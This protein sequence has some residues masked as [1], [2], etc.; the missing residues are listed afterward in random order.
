[1]KKYILLDWDGNLAKTLDVWL[2]VLRTVFEK[3]GIHL[4]DEEIASSFGAFN[5]YAKAW[6]VQDVDVAAEEADALAKQKLPDVE[7]YPDALEVLAALHVSDRKLAL[8]TTSPHRNV[9]HLLEKYDITRYFD[10]II[11]GDDVQNHKP[12]PEP[13][14]KAL[15]KLGGNKSEAIMI[16]DSDK[17]LGA[18]QNAG[19]DSILFYPPE[20]KK[21]YN[22]EQLQKLNPTHV[23]TDFRQVLEIV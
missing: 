12:H 18:A 23:I 19:I 5:Q 13:L 15:E 8:I 7:L 2:R 11:A 20:H 9:Q 16:G 14:E 21:F 10:I 4:T 22:L 1:M 6:G 17:D 3:R